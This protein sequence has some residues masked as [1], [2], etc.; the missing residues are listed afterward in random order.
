MSWLAYFGTFLTTAIGNVRD[1]V[2]APDGDLFFT[3]QTNGC[4]WKLS[5]GDGSL[6]TEAKLDSPI[7]LAID[8]SGSL[9]VS[10]VGGTSG[11]VWKV[12]P[13]GNIT[14]VAGGGVSVSDGIAATSAKLAT[15]FDLA[16]GPDGYLYVSDF[17]LLRVRRIKL[18]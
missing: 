6:A 1:V 15:P 10:T 12:V 17:G 2:R 18:Q 11:K 9:Y 16:V 13:G 4:I 5:G 7:G 14:H 3:D 8:S